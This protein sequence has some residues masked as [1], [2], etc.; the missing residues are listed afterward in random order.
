MLKGTDANSMYALVSQVQIEKGPRL[1]FP[2]FGFHY[3]AKNTVVKVIFLE[4][5]SNTQHEI[6]NSMENA[7]NNELEIENEWKY[8]FKNISDVSFISSAWQASS[9]VEWQVCSQ[10]CNKIFKKWYM[11]IELCN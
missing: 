5:S 2:H 9:E 6:M 4:T 3:M 7:L 1:L 11:P 10:V 8:F